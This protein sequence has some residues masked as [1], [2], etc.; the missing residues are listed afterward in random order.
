[1]QH[2]TNRQSTTRRRFGRIAPV[3]AALAAVSAVALA[4]SASAASSSPQTVSEI[5]TAK[6]SKLGTILVAGDSAVYTLKAGKTECTAACEKLF[7]PVI[8]ASGMTAATAG[9]GVDASKL[10]TTTTAS[11]DVQVTYDGEPLY[12]HAKDK[13]A[14]KAHDVSDKWGKWSTV[15]TK[16]NG[17]AGGS[18]GSGGSNG[19]GK[20]DAGSGGTAF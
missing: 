11:G 1:M 3:V 20:S 17:S 2:T 10:G 6:S 5:D 12:W 4:P 9:N 8:L 14:R 19:S 16:S 7:P 13:T 18:G 15:V